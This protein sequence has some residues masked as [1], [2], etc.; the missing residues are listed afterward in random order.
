MFWKMSI[1]LSRPL[2]SSQGH[3][4]PL[5]GAITCLQLQSTRLDDDPSL[6][7][8]CQDFAAMLAGVDLATADP[9]GLGGLLID[10]CRVDAL[11]DQQGCDEDREEL[12]ALHQELLLA[13]G[14]GLALYGQRQELARPASMRLAF[15]ELGLALGLQAVES[16]QHP[17]QA[18]EAAR[19][20]RALRKQILEFWQIPE[21]RQVATWTEHQ[22]INDVT[23]AAALAPAGVLE[24]PP[25][26]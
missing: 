19:R 11:L 13:A 1:D 3:H 14:R 18:L 26:P 15:R 25:A 10:A 22:D 9:L 6:D 17:G 5:D 2:V 20:Y 7:Q 12:E 8:P 4:D 24:L 16:I 21:H 23:L